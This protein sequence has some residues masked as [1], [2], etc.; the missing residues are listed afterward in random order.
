MPIKIPNDLPASKILKEENIFVMD[1][2]RALSQRIRPLKLI[3]VNI[4]PTKI[5]TET[6]LLR[7]LSNTPL[8]IEVD[9]LC[10]ESHNSKNTP[11]EHLME[12]YK[13]FNEIKDNKYD[14]LIVTGAPV[15]KLKFEDVDYWDELTK[16]FD[17]AN[18]NVFSSFFI[19]WA[20]QASLYYYYG[21]EK[22]QL[23]EK[24]T[25]VYHH[26][27]NPEKMR[28]RILRGFDYQFYAPHSRYTSVKKE[29]NRLMLDMEASLEETIRNSEDP[30]ET[31]LLYARIGNY[32]DF[33][34]LSNVNSDT[35]LSLL[36]EDNKEPLNAQEYLHFR[37]DLSAASRLVYLTDN[38]GEIVLDKL[39]IILLK[40]LCPELDIT[41]I[42]RG[43][44]VINDA[45]MEDAQ[46]IG[47]T[48][49]TTVIGNGNEVGGTW[50]PHISS[51]AREALESADLIIAKG[52][53]NYE[54]LHDCGLNIYYLFL[55]KCKWFQYQFNAKPLQGMFINERRI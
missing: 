39:V 14:G 23:K 34:A 52:Q 42:V 31:A 35:V 50:L 9:W 13:T 26:H 41:V 54:T 21:V 38:C 16:I 3:I 46:D 36:K 28:R 27:T 10:M 22:Y 51:E 44:P 33:A 6:Q 8:Q 19:C 15:E 2:T 55:C 17:W 1:E 48:E 45:T 43:F 5:V 29:Y 4:M 30:L 49:L 37:K 20:S 18:T 7:L 53:G 32:I 12:F 11:Q 40:E 47:L 24:L 25:G